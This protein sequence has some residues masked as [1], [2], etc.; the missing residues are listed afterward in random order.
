MMPMGTRSILLVEDDADI[1]M[2]EV[3]L[4]QRNGYRVHHCMQGEQALAY[5]QENR[6]VDLILMDIDLG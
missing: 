2:L 5:I 6:A 3:R 1:A 4:L